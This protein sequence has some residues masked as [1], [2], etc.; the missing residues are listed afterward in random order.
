MSCPRDLDPAAKAEAPAT[1]AVA[2]VS[3]HVF[4]EEGVDQPRRRRL[5][6]RWGRPKQQDPGD[7]S[8]RKGGEASRLPKGGSAG[9]K[10]PMVKCW[11][12][13]VEKEGD[14]VEE[15]T[16]RRTVVRD[17]SNAET[18]VRRP[19]ITNLTTAAEGRSS[20]KVE[21]SSS[22]RV[23]R[24]ERVDVGRA[25][26]ERAPT[27]YHRGKGEGRSTRDDLVTT[28]DD[29]RLGAK[30]APLQLPLS[31]DTYDCEGN[32]SLSSASSVAAQ[33]VSV[34]LLPLM[35]TA[36]TVTTDLIFEDS[37]F[38]DSGSSAA[39]ASSS[40]RNALD[41]GDVG[42]AVGSGDGATV[43]GGAAT[44]R[45]RGGPGPRQRTGSVDAFVRTRY[46]RRDNVTLFI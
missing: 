32:L 4:R 43:V 11:E 15:K 1:A 18:S 34:S 22:A 16:P 39:L 36:T 8:S 28:D 25:F 9:D 26:T 27:R 38:E 20:G 12:G 13:R 14:G 35:G 44:R 10:L 6:T 5:R 23:S 33:G 7:S 17:Q 21:S 30:I 31:E 19:V 45:K 42:G 24:G 40:E 46:E 2:D 41:I 29:E 37:S 3:R